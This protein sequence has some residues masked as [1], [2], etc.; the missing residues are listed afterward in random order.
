[1]AAAPQAVGDQLLKEMQGKPAPA[2]AVQPTAPTDLG[3]NY[4]TYRSNLQAQ[5]PGDALMKEMQSGQAAPAPQPAEPAAAPTAQPS[6]LSK[7]GSGAA[8]VGKDIAKGTLQES[9]RG[10]Y[11]GARNAVQQTYDKVDDFAGWATKALG[12]ENVGIPIPGMKHENTLSD[13]IAGTAGPTKVSDIVR[14]WIDKKSVADP[15]SVTGKLIQGVAQFV[16]GLALTKGIAPG[17]GGAIASAAHGAESLAVAFDPHQERLSNLIEKFPVLSNPVTRFLQ[18]KPDDSEA[19]GM[20]K[21]A[22]EGTGMGELASGFVKG[23]RLL[24][25]VGQAGD[26]VPTPK[27]G[28]PDDAFK[29][30]GDETAA[31]GE[32]FLRQEMPQVTPA[33]GTALKSAVEGEGAP[34]QVPSSA[35]GREMTPPKTY[36]N[37]ARID[38]PDDIKRAMQEIADARAAP[39]DQARAGVMTFEDIKASASQQNAWNILKARNEGEPLPADKLTAARQLWL[40]ATAKLVETARVVQG[41]PTEENLFALKKMQE[42]HGWIGDQVTGAITSGARSQSSLRIPVGP[43]DGRLDEVASRVQMLGGTDNVRDI[44]NRIVALADSS[45]PYAAQQ[46]QMFSSKS[47]YARSR[48]AVI[49]FFRDSLLSSPVSQARILSSNVSTAV[50]RMGERK[51]AEGI[52]HLMDTTNGVA[53]GEAAAMYSGWIGSFKDAMTFGW[54]A[55]Q[56]GATG[57]GIGSVPHEQFPSNLSAEALNLTGT[58]AGRIADFVGQAAS[59]GYG[60]GGRRAIIAQHDMA[61]TMAYGAS[62]QANAVR[63]ATREINAGELAEG[64]FSER[65]A[66]L[67]HGPD[68]APDEVIAAPSRAE[69]KYQAFL[70]DPGQDTIGKL[71]NVMLDARKEIPALNGVIP[72]VKIPSRILSYTFERT[73]LAPLMSDFRAKV[74]AG[75]ASRDLAL[76]QLAVGGMITSASADMVASGMLKGS[77]P[78]EKGLEQAQEREGMKRDSIK[79]GDGWYNIN[80]IHPVGKTMLLAADVA[81]A[82]QGGQHE[83]KDDEDTTK[84]AV[85]TALAIARTLT[86]ASYMQG[87]AN[88]FATLH[89]A[90][91]GGAGETAILSAEGSLIPQAIASVDRATDPYQREVYTMLDEFKSK[92]PGWSQ[93]LPPR[94]DLWGAPIPSGHDPLTRLAS[95]VQFQKETHSPIDDEILKQGMNIT[96]PGRNQTFGPAGEGVPID[97]SKYPK[98]YSRFLQLAGNEYKDPAWNLGAKDL[99]NE[100][101]SGNHPFSAVYNMKTDGPV[102]GKAEIVRG[103]INQYRA[104]ARRELLDES[105]KLQNQVDQLREQMQALKMPQ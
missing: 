103:I 33:E 35:A 43:A 60:F 47:V 34:E 95:P 26:I 101:V 75:G 74:A 90:K 58:T 85:G 12:I 21:N 59:W 44:A 10:V 69:A 4:V 102:G 8:A 52:S 84:I 24:Q 78:P 55:A 72:F 53:P 13:E 82:I 71:T 77:G 32:P 3:Q 28:L 22:I 17:G 38:A 37:F 2:P 66:S 73:P 65:V 45:S 61:L 41:A 93:S 1:M 42:V 46:L 11:T 50:W 15:Q 104:G 29:I 48:D 87:L 94:R 86:N 64:G 97:M 68:G 30:L 9:A 88:L 62:L 57:E 16:T 98:E 5:A 79:I 25:D 18:S 99:L 91:V 40:N 76:A 89:D 36:I 7:I 54:K 92:I 96:L 39:A 51:V 70:D 6:T 19:L 31:P 105:P 27:P 63:T 67:L 23:V 49:Q 56:T 100:I 20:F 81:E 14:N 83:L 80:G